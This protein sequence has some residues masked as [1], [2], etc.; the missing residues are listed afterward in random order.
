MAEA[1]G[2]GVCVL[3]KRRCGHCSI[4]FVVLIGLGLFA[5]ALNIH[6]CV[7]LGACI[8]EQNM[9]VRVCICVYMCESVCV[10]VCVCVFE[11]KL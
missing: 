2:T 4:L 3:L 6:V 11:L 7:H 5:S 8:C 9:Y 10:Y 1:V